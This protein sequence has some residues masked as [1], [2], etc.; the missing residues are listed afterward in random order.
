METPDLTSFDA[1]LI[2][3]S[4][5]KDSQTALRV[6]CLAA[7]EAG[8]L[9]RVTV[10]YNDLGSRVTWPGTLALA[11]AQAA[12][13]GVRFEMRSKPG[14][15]LLDDIRGRGKFPDAA[16]RWC[17]SDHKRGPGRTLLTALVRELGLDRPARVLQVY[18]FRAEESD[19]R[20]RKV[21][22]AFNEGA[23]NQTRRHVWDW[24]P[25]HAWTADEVWADIRASGVPYHSAYDQGMSRLS[26]SFCVLASRADLLRACRLRPDVAQEYAAVEVEIG[27]RFQK[28]A[29]MA[30][31]I[32]QAAASP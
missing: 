23:S 25:I 12:H 2:N 1:I 14:G 8:V 16:R 13:Y 11:K 29:S 18:G 7:A 21:P 26:C 19:Q 30:E 22:Y 17:T 15:D 3:S 28:A 4:A 9:N 32:Q 6:V 27:H 24:Y 5:G 31:L 10:Q 20:A